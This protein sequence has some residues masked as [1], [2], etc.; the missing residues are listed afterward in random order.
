MT[1]GICPHC[2]ESTAPHLTGCRRSIITVLGPATVPP[3]AD[4]A[5]LASANRALM[6]ENE[7]I[8]AERDAALRDVARLCDVLDTVRDALAESG[9]CVAAVG[10]D[11][12]KM[13]RGLMEESAG[14]L[15]ALEAVG[16]ERRQE[17]RR[18]CRAEGERDEALRLLRNAVNACLVGAT[19][20]RSAVTAGWFRAEASSLQ[21]F[22][23]RTEGE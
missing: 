20:A 4:P 7:R 19:E 1:P 10:A 11:Y 21:A 15:R 18:A 13:I 8:A 3:P 16:E 6:E 9:V 2:G 5:L 17:W 14:R 23:A 22:L 12:A